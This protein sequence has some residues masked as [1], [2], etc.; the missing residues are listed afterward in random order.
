MPNQIVASNRNL[1]TRLLEFFG[2]RIVL[3]VFRRKL[4][5]FEHS[6]RPPDLAEFALAPS[7]DWRAVL[8][9]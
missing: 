2:G 6:L 9:R 7:L 4:A 8:R 3:P 1:T 5:R